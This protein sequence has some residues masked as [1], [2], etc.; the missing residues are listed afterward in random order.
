M[1]CFQVLTRV[2]IGRRALDISA[3]EAI[4]PPA[5]SSPRTTSQAPTARMIDCWVYCTNFTKACT[6][7]AA[8]CAS[9]WLPICPS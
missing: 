4:I 5:D 2:L 3:F 8:R 1:N 7:I 6:R 9:I